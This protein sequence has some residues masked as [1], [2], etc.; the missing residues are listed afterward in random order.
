M[1]IEA[2]CKGL[3][4]IPH[5]AGVAFRVWAPHAER[6]CVIG[7]FNG[8]ENGKHPLQAEENGNWYADVAQAR[9][10]DQYKFVLTTAQGEFKRIDPYARAVTSSCRPVGV[11]AWPGAQVALADTGGLPPRKSGCTSRPMCHSCSTI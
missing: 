5:A 3:G 6:V 9:V 2:G 8:W 1:R 7:T 11:W 4:A 10:G